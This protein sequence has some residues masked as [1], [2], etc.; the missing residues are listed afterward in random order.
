MKKSLALLLALTMGVTLLAGCGG[1]NGSGGGGGGTGGTGGGK[2]ATVTVNQ[3]DH[4]S[5]SVKYPSGSFTPEQNEYATDN[6]ML[7]NVEELGSGGYSVAK[8]TGNKFNISLGYY[9][10]SSGYDAYKQY[11]FEHQKRGN[12]KEVTYDGLDGF[13]YYNTYSDGYAYVLFPE[14]EGGSGGGNWMRM[15]ALYVGDEGTATLD[16]L[17]E[18]FES[19]EAQDIIKTLK[20]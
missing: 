4:G 6:E 19:Q 5:I 12:P 9:N 7:S 2:T 10:Y 15:L 20:F 11:V 1:G 3:T 16:E 17:T 18:L 8:L 14:A 13:M